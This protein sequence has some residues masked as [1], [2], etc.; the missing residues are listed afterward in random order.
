M[1][2]A[3]ARSS[4]ESLGVAPSSAESGRREWGGH[5]LQRV[6]GG[7]VGGGRWQRIACQRWASTR[8]FSKALKREE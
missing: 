6:E 7:Q 2:G 3:G 4:V 1:S 5:T 8:D